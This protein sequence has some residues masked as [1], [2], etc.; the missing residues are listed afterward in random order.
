MGASASAD[1]HYVSI[2]PANGANTPVEIFESDTPLIVE[3][4]VLLTDSGG[5]G[6]TK[7]GLGRREVLRIPDDEYAP[8]PPVNL[9]IQSGRYRYPPEGL[10]GGKH[11]A[12][13]QFLVS[14]KNGNPFGLTRMNPGDVI[15]MD[16]AGGG[17]FGDPLDR[18]PEMVQE[19]VIQGYVSLEKARE[20]Y[21]VVIDPATMK[22]D[23]AATENLRRSMKA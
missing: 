22:A 21:G 1:G 16:A 17:G 3:Q 20:D 12:K 6:R 18:D 8:L 23:L 13:A 2:F 7:G 5:T 4:R 11:G 15:V 14:G 19:D 10:F 9:G